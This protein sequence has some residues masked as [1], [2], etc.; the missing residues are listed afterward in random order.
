M[1]IAPQIGKKTSFR[2]FGVLNANQTRFLDESQVVMRSFSYTNEP[3]FELWTVFAKKR[4][5]PCESS[6]SVGGSAG[7]F[8]GYLKVQLFVL[9]L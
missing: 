2:V 3:I 5:F 7:G 6:R 9:F 8:F 4:V 1:L